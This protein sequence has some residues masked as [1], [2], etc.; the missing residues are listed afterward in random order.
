MNADQCVLISG[1]SGGGK[2][3]LLV[4]LGQRGYATVDEPGRR[5]V[6]QELLDN[7]QALPW[8]DEIAFA[9]RT[10]ALAL[11]DRMNAHHASG[12]VFFDRGMIDAATALQHLTGESAQATLGQSPRYHPKLFLTPPLARDLSCRP[13]AT[14]RFGCSHCRVPP[15]GRYVSLARLC[16]DGVAQDQ[17]A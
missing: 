11:A 16:G 7:G 6:K 5:I 10:F 9:R 4:E 14:A 8:V 13:G 1:C 2:S 12:W 15:T 3:T 17:R